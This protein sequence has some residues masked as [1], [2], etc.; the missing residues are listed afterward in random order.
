MNAL[1]FHGKTVVSI[2]F[3]GENRICALTMIVNKGPE[4][5]ISLDSLWFNEN[6]L[7]SNYLLYP[8]CSFQHNFRKQRENTNT[9]TVKPLSILQHNHFY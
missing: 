5:Y 8:L 4:R 6:V 7:L 9:D 2:D 3:C 1:K